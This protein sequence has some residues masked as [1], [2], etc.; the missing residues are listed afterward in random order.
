MAEKA[1]D[2]PIWRL[3][4]VKNFSLTH[5]LLV[6]CL[7]VI[8]LIYQPT[9]FAEANHQ[10]QTASNKK[11]E[12]IIQP[13]IQLRIEKITNEKGKKLVLVKLTESKTNK[14]ITLKDLS[15]VHTQKIHMLVID[16]SLSDYSHVHPVETKIPGLYE[17]AWQPSMKSANYRIW[18][19]LLP[20]KTKQQEYIIADLYKAKTTKAKIIP[21]LSM[22]SLVEGY[23]F[24][25][26]F[27]QSQLHPGQAAMGKIEV[28]DAQNK[29]IH[30]LEPIMGAYAHIVGFNDDFK[31]VVH[32][33]PMGTEPTKASDRGGPMLEFHIEPEKS[34]YIKL[35]AQVKINNKEFFVPFGVYVQK[36]EGDF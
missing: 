17:F 4:I 14:P 1:P 2:I 20:V 35:F 11:A 23:K 26:S 30:N 33:H 36:P 3:M 9:A 34:G 25:L 16:D 13:S 28:R 10:H 8:S 29:P 7:P 21:S 27:D 31:T 15:E 24:K 18:A 6:L 5:P 22:E 19:D 32:I 12:Q